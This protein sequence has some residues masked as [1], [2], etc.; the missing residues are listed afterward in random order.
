MHGTSRIADSRADGFAFNH[1]HLVCG[2]VLIDF[3]V[4]GVD[5]KGLRLAARGREGEVIERPVGTCDGERSLVEVGSVIFAFVGCLSGG[6]G[7]I[8]QEAHIAVDEVGSDGEEAVLEEI[9]RQDDVL[10]LRRIVDE[11]VAF[12]AVAVAQDDVVELKAG[13]RF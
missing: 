10:V 8:R 9:S 5:L 4:V 3:L 13:G 1:R 11:A 6:A 2:E 7:K 12:K